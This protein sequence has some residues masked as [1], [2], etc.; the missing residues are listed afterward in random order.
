MRPIEASV[1]ARCAI[2]AASKATRTSDLV[3]WPYIEQWE[4]ELQLVAYVPLDGRPNYLGY[5]DPD[6]LGAVD[7]KKNKSGVTICTGFDIGQHSRDYVL[8]LP[9]SAQIAADLARYAAP[10][11]K[12]DACRALYETRGYKLPC[13]E[14]ALAINHYVRSDKV[15]RFVKVYN[16]KRS[17]GTASYEQLPALIRTAMMSFAFQYGEYGEWKGETA[18]TYWAAITRQDWTEAARILVQ[19]YKTAYVSRRRAEAELYRLALV[20]LPSP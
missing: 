7:S 12:L 13:I 11:T 18:R 8:K 14:D 19:D 5:K 6:T 4:G 20:K 9:V 16:S 10:K 3:L 1:G 15:E 2:A 17:A